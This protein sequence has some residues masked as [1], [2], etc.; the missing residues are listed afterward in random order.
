MTIESLKE[1]IEHLPDQDRR[2]LADWFSE[3][4][5]REWDNQLERDFAPGGRGEFLLEKV[6]AG[7]AAGKFRDIEDVCAERKQDDGRA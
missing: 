4:E 7:I 6:E 5:Q 2:K 3:L 1:A